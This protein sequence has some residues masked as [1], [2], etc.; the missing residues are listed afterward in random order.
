[1]P[2][3]SITTLP[4]ETYSST[5]TI[6]G[7]I[8]GSEGENV[9]YKIND[10]EWSKFAPTHTINAVI[11]LTLG[12]NTITITA[13]NEIGDQSIWTHTIECLNHYPVL[14]DVFLSRVCVYNEN[15]EVTMT[16]VDEDNDE[17][18]YRVI[19]NGEVFNDWTGLEPSP[20]TITVIIPARKLSLGSNTIRV[21]GRDS[22]G[23]TE[24]TELTVYK[25]SLIMTYISS[26]HSNVNY[27]DDP[28][29]K[30]DTDKSALIKLPFNPNHGYIKNAILILAVKSMTE[31]NIKI[32]KITSSWDHL[33][34]TKDI[35][36]SYDVSTVK[37]I[38]VTE[39]T[40]VIDVSFA[41]ENGII[42]FSDGGAV[43][44]DITGHVAEVITQPTVLI[45][46]DVI[47]NNKVLIKWKPLIMQR[48][49]AF[50]SLELLRST[51]PTMEGAEV[52]FSTTH[53]YKTEYK[54]ET[55]SKGNYYYQIVVR[56]QDIAYQGNQ[57]DFDFEDA[58]LFQYDA[59]LEFVGGVVRFR[60]LP[61]VTESIN[62]QYMIY[63]NTKLEIVGGRLRLIGTEVE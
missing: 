31:G 49:D 58:H 56:Y 41:D 10:G 29:V 42:I 5:I 62:A 63:D 55:I 53:S 19:L 2:E 43:E 9:R 30:V 34:V 44:F 18:Q 28:Y 32:A 25:K 16:L 47:Y 11:T 22:R 39:G 51:S 23:Y 15:I 24:Y 57:L 33:T 40:L 3:I 61:E 46:P 12:T 45:Q 37:I 52:V 35:L 7:T 13:E 27:F 1:M 21:E 26:E 36:P 4:T 6:T 14:A 38:P 60:T 8:S 48:P 20:I 59:L 54:D 50:I 17:V